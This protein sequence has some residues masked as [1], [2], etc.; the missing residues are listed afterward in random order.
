MDATDKN[1]RQMIAALSP[2]KKEN[3]YHL[4]TSFYGRNNI[5]NMIRKAFEEG[6]VKYIRDKKISLLAGHDAYL[7]QANDNILQKSDIVNSFNRQIIETSA[8]VQEEKPNHPRKNDIV[9][10]YRITAPVNINDEF[11]NISVLVAED[12]QGRKYYTLENKGLVQDTSV[13]RGLAQTQK[14][15]SFYDI[16]IYVNKEN[17]KQNNGSANLN[18]KGLFDSKQGLIK[19]FESADFSTLPHELAHY[20]LNNMWNYVRSGNASERYQQR[21][22]VI[23]NWLGITPEQTL[24]TRRRTAKSLCLYSE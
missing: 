15:N 1:G 13:E 22:N 19:I 18:P 12:T 5:D 23:A 4:I 21:W 14:G 20:W 6:K 7:S 24:I 2:S 16:N 17:V 3:G 11:N 8:N 10:F 9:R